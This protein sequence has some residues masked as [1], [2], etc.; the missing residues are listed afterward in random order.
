MEKSKVYAIV[1]IEEDQ[2]SV[3]CVCTIFCDQGSNENSNYYSSALLFS[4]VLENLLKNFQL[5]KEKKSLIQLSWEAARVK[6]VEDVFVATDD[7]R[8]RVEV[9]SFGAKVIMTSKNAKMELNGVQ[10]R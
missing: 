10:R 6:N 1:V 5:V 2:P 8:I 3:S 4:K 7:D 9:K